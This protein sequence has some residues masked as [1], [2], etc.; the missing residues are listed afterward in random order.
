M[1]VYEIGLGCISVEFVEGLVYLYD[2]CKLGVV[3]VVEM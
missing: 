3:V 2:V 1:V